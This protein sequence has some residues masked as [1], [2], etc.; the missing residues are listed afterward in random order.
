LSFSRTGCGCCS[1]TQA[2]HGTIVDAKL[3][4]Y[5]G[6]CHQH[7]QQSSHPPSYGTAVQFVRYRLGRGRTAAY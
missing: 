7:L 3:A 4:M 2:H 5:S 1:F 6:D